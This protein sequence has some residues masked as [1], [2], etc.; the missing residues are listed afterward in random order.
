MNETI[1]NMTKQTEN[2]KILE[3]SHTFDL[4]PPCCENKAANA[5]APEFAVSL[6]YAEIQDIDP[7]TLKPKDPD[8]I[9]GHYTAMMWRDTKDMGCA[10]WPVNPN[11]DPYHDSIWTCLYTSPVPNQMT[12]LQEQL[13]N[14]VQRS[15]TQ[16]G[17]HHSMDY[18]CMREYPEVYNVTATGFHLHEQAFFEAFWNFD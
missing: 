11:G 10:A 12:Q 14:L 4:D 1:V 3:H 16:V 15:T 7:V 6:W 13:P 5:R 9:V 18:C 2:F 8:D 17:R